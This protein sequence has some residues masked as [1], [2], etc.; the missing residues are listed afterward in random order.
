M[1]R[2]VSPQ[3][4]PKMQRGF[5]LIE[6]MVAS[7]FFVISLAAIF[8]LHV[9]A[10]GMMVR[11]KGFDAATSILL[12][13]SELIQVLAPQDVQTLLTT[14]NGK[15]YDRNGI[16]LPKGSSGA[17]YTLNTS[18]IPGSGTYKH[19]TLK[20]SWKES[21]SASPHAITTDTLVNLP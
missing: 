8:T 2:G 16:P 14:A 15:G 5:T 4:A 21:G 13:M 10:S 1:N 3:H 18:L 17:F 6:V 12:N 19:L 11:A 7:V 20:V 9:N